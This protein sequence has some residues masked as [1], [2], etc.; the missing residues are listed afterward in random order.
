MSP[1]R[2]G[3]SST[4]PLS[5]TLRHRGETMPHLLAYKN[6]NNRHL[7]R[8]NN[9][10]S[11]AKKHLGAGYFNYTMSNDGFKNFIWGE[12]YHS[13]NVDKA[14]GYTG[15]FSRAGEE[16]V[17]DSL[18]NAVKSGSSSWPYQ[19]NDWNTQSWGQPCYWYFSGGMCLSGKAEPNAASE[20]ALAV[21]AYH[22][23]LPEAYRRFDVVDAKIVW[24]GLGSFVQ[25]SVRPTNSP[26]FYAMKTWDD[27]NSCWGNNYKLEADHYQDAQSIAVHVI[28]GATLS[29]SNFNPAKCFF[30]YDNTSSHTMYEARNLWESCRNRIGRDPTDADLL[31]WFNVDMSDSYNS[32]WRAWT[33]QGSRGDYPS[34]TRFAN[35]VYA[36]SHGGTE[37]AKLLFS[38]SS[39]WEI[40]YIS[41]A[42]DY[43]Q[44][45]DYV[46]PEL[47]LND[48]DK[49]AILSA[50]GLW[51]IVHGLPYLSRSCLTGGSHLPTS[52]FQWEGGPW[53]GKS[54]S[55]V[56]GRY[57]GVGIESLDTFQLQLTLG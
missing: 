48:D 19:G 50:G 53:R 47:G 51:I 43:P 56:V 39:G 41:G 4:R 16:A 36:T 31:S 17:A 22:F 34:S 11:S 35:H 5:A 30:V 24:S 7:V 57:V 33:W 37:T 2:C 9:S 10:P 27:N 29:R 20:A 45:G 13:G 15:A 49:S 44:T 38:N 28:H 21:T 25:N 32:H 8:W 18:L 3:T 42:A 26:K 12:S 52:S 1:Q 54:N 6:N 23:T 55:S 40:P 14:C 46:L